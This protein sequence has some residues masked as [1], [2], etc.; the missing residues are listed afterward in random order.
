MKPLK[1]TMSAFGPYSKETV[2]DF[3]V[4]GA[5]SIFLITGDTGSGKTTIFD[6][7]SFALYGEVSGGKARK[8]AGSMRSDYAGGD[9]PTFV[10]YEFKHKDGHYLL[11]RNPAYE[12]LKK[13]GQGYTTEAA[14]AY[15]KDLN[16]GMEIAG[17]DRVNNKIFELLSLT[18]EQF[19]QTMM[20]AQGD[21]MKI[22]NAGSEERRVL[23]QK[24]FDTK[25]YYDIQQL[26]KEMYGEQKQKYEDYR[27]DILNSFSRINA[28]EEINSYLDDSVNID[29]VLSL[30]GDYLY[31]LKNRNEELKKDYQIKDKEHDNLLKRI[32]KATK[33]NDDFVQ[34]QKLKQLQQQ[35][36]SQKAE[37]DEYN[38]QLQ[39]AQACLKIE[40][41]EEL[42]LSNKRSYNERQKE[43]QKLNDHL[44]ILKKD[45]P[46][47]KEAY[48][49]VEKE[50]LHDLP[51]LKKDN[52]KYE[53][54]KEYL[55]NRQILQTDLSKNLEKLHQMEDEYS[56]IN[57][58]YIDMRNKYFASQYGIIA[59]ELKNGQACPV[60][61]SLKHPS[62]ASFVSEEIS[63]ESLEK[64]EKKRDD[65]LKLLQSQETVCKTLE[66]D[67]KNNL[68]SFN[69]LK[70][71]EDMDFDN[72]ISKN[73]R[74]IRD[75][76]ENYPKIK[77]EYEDLNKDYL[78]SLARQ[79]EV[80]SNIESDKEKSGK[81]YDSFIEQLKNNNFNDENDYHSAKLAEKEMK[82]LEI[83]IENYRNKALSNSQQIKQLEDGLQ[84][85]QLE[86]L[87]VLN[88]EELELKKLMLD[89]SR[90]ISLFTMNAQTNDKE[91]WYLK[92]ISR[93]FNTLNKEY[94][95]VEELYQNIS[96]TKSK[97]IRL[98]FEAYVQQYYFRQVIAAANKRLAVLSDEVFILRQKP[99][100][101]NMRSQAGLDLDVYD[102]QTGSWRD[103]STLSGGES[104]MASLALA[105][106]LSDVVQARSGGIRMDSMFIDEG[107]GSLSDNAL[108]QA[109]RLLND[110]ADGD[111]LIGIIS[112]VDN[113]KERIDKK[114]IIRKGSEGSHLNIEI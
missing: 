41:Y 107:F 89:L 15:F 59:R 20:I 47:K 8:D 94:A 52:E 56:L 40:K 84:G 88:N 14:A 29:K 22:I 19:S 104:F 44:V 37:T 90:N 55:K 11:H 69:K 112:H 62:P 77:K 79:K 70:L 111:R 64:N 83:K 49:K 76:N 3:T 92:D 99:E 100:A 75:I 35:I 109:V 85:E 71:K 72:L 108:N 10:E 95:L 31:D 18:R 16:S 106:G 34:L 105:L 21:F 39:R 101:K 48:A 36:N 25:K 58:S 1:L 23:F 45:L 30:L 74:L 43:L 46:D 113:L 93:K 24:I 5:N 32:A 82:Q 4:F 13:N 51:L 17:V 6:A 61:G 38:K 27:R 9:V 65:A 28:S 96:G 80:C 67:L 97:T 66:N 7:I 78:E 98:T 54:A 91:Y 26:L 60:C 87:D 42:F 63:A 53:E 81:A 33:T 73:K 57:E 102:N 12:R 50:F 114:I 110:L 86:N 103:V 68:Q 2:I